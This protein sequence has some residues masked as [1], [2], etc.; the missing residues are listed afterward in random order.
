MRA[1]FLL[2]GLSAV[3]SLAIAVERLLLRPARRRRVARETDA[4]IAATVLAH[5]TLLHDALRALPPLSPLELTPQMQTPA[6]GQ[7]NG[8]GDAEA[9]RREQTAPPIY[10]RATTADNTALTGVQVRG[11]IS[12][13][14]LVSLTC[15]AC[16]ADLLPVLTE[17]LVS[18][19]PC[20]RRAALRRLS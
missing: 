3:V 19:C 10:A 12:S 20:T 9:P 8:G 15:K 17:A 4:R 1:L 14:A 11:R 18:G 13:R 2:L 16:G 5:S 6:P 7:G